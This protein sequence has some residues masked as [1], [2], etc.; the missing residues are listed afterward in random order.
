MVSDTDRRGGQIFACDLFEALTRQGVNG[1]LFALVPGKVGGLEAEVLGESRFS[2]RLVGTLRHLMREHDV[3]IAHGSTTV[4]A[5]AMAGGGKERPFVVRQISE[6]SFWLDGFCRRFRVGLYLR[7]AA[8][9]VALAESAGK[10]LA[11]LTRVDKN[12]LRSVPNGV[13]AERFPLGDR[14]A[15]KRA[16][17]ELGLPLEGTIFCSVGAL[18]FEKGTDRVIAAAGSVPEAHLAIAGDGPER[19]NLER[20]ARQLAPGRVSFLGSLRTTVPVYHASD[21]LVIASRAGDSMPAVIIEA[22]FCGIPSIATEVG[23]ISAMIDP[24]NT[25]VTVPRQRDDLI[26]EAIR[27][28]DR[29][30][31]W[32]VQAGQEARKRCLGLYEIQPVAR[33]WMDVLSEVIEQHPKPPHTRP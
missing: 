19:K 15:S 18:V 9:V 1:S 26:R 10:E 2:G 21:A 8:R 20:L 17:R 12:K 30:R 31:S 6:S 25:G 3:T 29:D 23:A 28:A 33:G 14:E 11:R 7:R 5:C 24:G 32:R 27:R 22:A 16:R 4:L 13:P